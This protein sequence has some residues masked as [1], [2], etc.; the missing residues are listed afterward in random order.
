M[1]AAKFRLSSPGANAF[2][3]CLRLRPINPP[4]A[5]NQPRNGLPMPGDHNLFPA[6]YPIEQGAELVFSFKSSKFM[7][8]VSQFI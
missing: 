4:G 3:C 7:H 1:E 8:G 5:R 2:G 6:L